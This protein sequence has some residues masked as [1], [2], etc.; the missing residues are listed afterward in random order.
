MLRVS[1]QLVTHARHERVLQLPTPIHDARTLRTLALLD[2]ESHPPDAAIDRVTVR[3]D[4]TPARTVQHTLFTR[5]L[6]APEQISTLVARLGALMG[7][8]RCGAPAAVDSWQPGAFTMRTFA[9]AE[10]MAPS[11]HRRSTS[12]ATP[13]V[14]VALR[15]FRVPVAAR[16]RVEHDV[17]VRVTTDRRGLTG[18]GVEACA[19]PWRTSGG[20]W[21]SADER[22]RWDREE[23]DLTVSD[24]VTYRVFHDRC[25]DAWFLDGVVD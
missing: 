24:G 16:V 21:A 3:V 19:G 25:G 23:W 2:L 22:G 4:P 6:P 7:E 18:G 15:R 9:P 5:P 1:L 20:W 11:V 14:T 13:I 12:T 10:Q 17:P 8:G